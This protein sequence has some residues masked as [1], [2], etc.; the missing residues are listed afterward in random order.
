MTKHKMNTQEL[1]AAIYEKG[2][3]IIEQMVKRQNENL[4]GTTLISADIS[5]K[6]Q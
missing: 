5:K 1:K 4:L 6:I 2:A 3:K